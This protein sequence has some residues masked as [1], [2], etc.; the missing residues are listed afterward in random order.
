MINSGTREKRLTIN[1]LREI[2]LLKQR[3]TIIEFARQRLH[4]NQK[5]FCIDWP[6]DKQRN[7]P[8]CDCII[9]WKT[10]TNNLV[11]EHTELESYPG[12]L[13]DNHKFLKQFYPLENEYAWN[14]FSIH[15]AVPSF[16]LQNNCNWAEITKNLKNYLDDH[17]ASLSFET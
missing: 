3:S 11:I 6:E 2:R 17:V 7:I 15:I 5:I 10:G 1:T 13:E 8:E 12:Q 16:V 14:D 9:S 4:K